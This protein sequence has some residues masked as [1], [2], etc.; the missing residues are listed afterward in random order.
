MTIT[1]HHIHRIAAVAVL[2]LVLLVL[3]ATAIGSG[4]SRPVA[5]AVPGSQATT[6]W[7]A[8]HNQSR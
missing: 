2:I 8:A 1:H 3:A 7:L 4:S 6:A 5:P